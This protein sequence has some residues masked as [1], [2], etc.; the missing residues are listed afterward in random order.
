M[1]SV[2]RCPRE[3]E[4]LGKQSIKTKRKE[5]HREGWDP[6]KAARGQSCVSRPQTRVEHWVV[7]LVEQIVGVVLA[8][9]SSLWKC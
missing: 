4:G 1:F 7:V 6:A 5:S 8:R 9:S 3:A 2:N